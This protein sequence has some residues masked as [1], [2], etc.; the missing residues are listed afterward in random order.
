MKNDF[1]VWKPKK[2][3]LVALLV[4]LV[5]EDMKEKVIMNF[6]SGSAVVKLVL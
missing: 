6:C 4:I 5:V 3:P 2:Q 1:E